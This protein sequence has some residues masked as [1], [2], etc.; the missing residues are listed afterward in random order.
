MT[1]VYLC[2]DE[3]VW[4][5]QMEQAFTSFMVSRIGRSRSSAELHALLSFLNA[6]GKIRP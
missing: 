2:D 3:P 6:C 1:Q 4:I 5:E